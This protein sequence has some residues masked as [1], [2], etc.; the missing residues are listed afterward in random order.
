MD[1]DKKI[2]MLASAASIIAGL[3]V[4]FIIMLLLGGANAFYGFWLLLSGGIDQGLYSLGSVLYYAAPIILTGLSVAFAFKTGLFNIGASGQFLIGSITAL[5]IG[6]NWTFLGPIHW[7]VA[8]LLGMFAGFVWGLIPGILKAFRNVHEVVATIMLNY[9]AAWLTVWL[10]QKANLIKTGTDKTI[11]AADSAILPDFGLGTI[12]GGNSSVNIGILIAIIVAILL[13][14]I[15][16]KTTFGYELKAV[17]YNKD[18]AKYAGINE[19]RSLILSMGIAGALAGLGGAIYALGYGSSLSATLTVPQQGFDGITVALL[20]LSSPIGVIFTGIFI[21]YIQ[22]G[23]PLLQLADYSS[24]MVNVIV[25]V[26]IYFSALSTVFSIY[27]RKFVKDD[28][29]TIGGNK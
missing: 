5:I 23:G 26:I 4:G 28:E 24:D 21:A 18:A 17:G 22:V 8:L 1:Y 7:L 20:A 9:I 19:K 11:A 29:D 6:V 16:E 10:I 25:A 13:Y 27:I 3:L 14:V 12:F 15:L 2:G